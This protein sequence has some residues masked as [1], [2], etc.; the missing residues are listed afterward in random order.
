M[1]APSVD[2][3]VLLRGFSAR[4]GSDRKNWRAHFDLL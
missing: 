1:N 3:I 4:V 2:S